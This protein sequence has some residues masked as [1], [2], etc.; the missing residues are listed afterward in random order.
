MMVPEEDFHAAVLDRLQN[1]PDVLSLVPVERIF[2]D[3]TTGA[4]FP[5][6]M[7]GQANSI[8]DDSECI[9]GVEHFLM[10]HAYSRYPGSLEIKR[11][12]HFI[13]KAL[14][15]VDLEL[16]DHAL[17]SIWVETVDIIPDPSDA[18]TRHGVIRVEALIE[19]IEA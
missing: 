7:F 15:R 8:E 16:T 3:V 11:L 12:C 14:H 1:D 5:Y 9:T 10:V 19:E 13:K 6:I 17:N 2:D 18:I 4:E